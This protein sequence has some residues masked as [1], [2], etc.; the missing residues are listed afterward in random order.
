M[1]LYCL[2]CAVS[3]YG[4]RSAGGDIVNQPKTMDLTQTRLKFFG[5]RG[6]HRN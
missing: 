2:T 1:G 3:I 6:S 4:D 5:G